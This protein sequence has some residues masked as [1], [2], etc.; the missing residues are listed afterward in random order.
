MKFEATDMLAQPQKLRML[1]GSINPGIVADHGDRM[2][3]K[4]TIVGITQFA[5]PIVAI[6]CYASCR[7]R[8]RG[9]DLAMS[10][11]GRGIVAG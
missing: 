6:G 4:R 9:I 1:D 3:M 2:V 11:V 10:F 7:S 5:L 8:I